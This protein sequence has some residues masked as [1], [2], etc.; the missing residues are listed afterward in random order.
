MP[1]RIL[2]DQHSYSKL[3]SRAVTQKGTNCQPENPLEAGCD[4]PV[5]DKNLLRES[6]F[7]RRND[8]RRAKLPNTGLWSAGN[9]Q[10]IGANGR[11][12]GEVERKNPPPNAGFCCIGS[13]LD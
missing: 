9:L 11:R 3:N 13:A 1:A 4:Q 5:G 7:D 10:R 8:D 2:A 6:F 12:V